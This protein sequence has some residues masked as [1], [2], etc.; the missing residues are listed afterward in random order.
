MI[1]CKDNGDVELTVGG[2]MYEYRNGWGKTVL[3]TAISSLRKAV[4]QIAGYNT[5]QLNLVFD[6][7]TGRRGF[8]EI[9]GRV[10]A[11]DRTDGQ[12]RTT[13][14]DYSRLGLKENA[15][16]EEVVFALGAELVKDVKFNAENWAYK[17]IHEDEADDVKCT[18]YALEMLRMIMDLNV[19]CTN[20]QKQYNVPVIERIK[21][22]QQMEIRLLKSSIV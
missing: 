11:I 14:I 4:I 12:F 13:K 20:A 18:Q 16:I 15:P 2:V 10:F 22:E 17:L 19:D 3:E 6:D 21:K 7:G 5:P 9:D 1:I 8:T